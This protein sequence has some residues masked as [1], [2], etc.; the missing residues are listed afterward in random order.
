MKHTKPSTKVV[1]V[2]FGLIAVFVLVAGPVAAAE[3]STAAK[4]PTPG[5]SFAVYGD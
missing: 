3:K 4:K 2:L 5:F 1:S